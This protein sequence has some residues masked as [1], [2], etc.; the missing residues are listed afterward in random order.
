MC[1]LVTHPRTHTRNELAS[2]FWSDIPDAQALK[3]LRN[4]LPVLRS[5]LGS[6]LII[7]RYT[8]TFNRYVPYHLDVEAF[9]RICGT[10]IDHTPS[11]ALWEGVSLYQDDFLAGFYVRNA[12]LFEEWMLLQR[13]HLRRL[14]IEALDT[15]AIRHIQQAEYQTALVATRRLL[16]LEPWRETTHQQQMFIF[17]RQGQRNSALAQYDLCCRILAAEFGLEPLPETTRLY[18]QIKADEIERDTSTEPHTRHAVHRS[19][20]HYPQT[21]GTVHPPAPTPMA[22][23]ADGT[24]LADSTPA[25]T[26]QIWHIPNGQV[27]HTLHGHTAPV[28]VLA[29]SPDGHLLAS[30]SADHTVRLWG[31]TS[32]HLR[33]TLRGH[34]APITALAF[35]PDGHL[36]ASGSADHTVRLWDVASGTL[37][38]IL[39]CHASPITA[40]TFPPETERLISSSSDGLVCVWDCTTGASL[41]KFHTSRQP[42]AASHQQGT[43]VS[44]HSVARSWLVWEPGVTGATL[45]YCVLL[46][47]SSLPG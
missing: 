31:T 4:I 27:Q 6:H 16:E 30:G 17:A 47:V 19:P 42:P 24:F 36:L 1:Y 11:V 8:V 15:L 38:H 3:N 21:V 37:Q 28:T 5:V 26:I 40:L 22:V 9:Q 41:K 39:D 12:P 44:Q 35:S 13:E 34:T 32:G 45:M 23:R 33:H 25:H 46:V 18:E 43:P 29:F 7:T 20:A 10:S 2:L 14:I